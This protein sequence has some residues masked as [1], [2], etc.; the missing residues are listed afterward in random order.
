[1]PRSARLIAVMI[2]WIPAPI[3][4]ASDSL[5][6]APSVPSTN[7]TLDLVSTNLPSRRTIGTNAAP[8]AKTPAA[9]TPKSS[10]LLEI[11]IFYLS[12]GFTI[13]I[14]NVINLYL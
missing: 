3:I 9:P 12:N 14:Y 5:G 4:T 2:P 11:F 6:R 10:F 8:P 1:M 7:D 13:Y